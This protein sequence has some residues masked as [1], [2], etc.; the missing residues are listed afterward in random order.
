MYKYY[1]VQTGQLLFLISFGLGNKNY[2]SY[3]SKKKVFF[4]F[5]SKNYSF[6]LSPAS[7]NGFC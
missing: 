5:E 1:K 3:G 6:M 4:A 7:L 2:A